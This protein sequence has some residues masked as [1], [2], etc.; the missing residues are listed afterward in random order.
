MSVGLVEERYCLH[1]QYD[2]RIIFASRVIAHAAL[3]DAIYMIHIFVFLS[4]SSSSYLYPILLFY[5]SFYYYDGVRVV[6]CNVY[7]CSMSADRQLWYEDVRRRCYDVYIQE[8][9]RRKHDV[10]H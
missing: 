10:L 9:K 6:V 1:A 2:I 8:C 5:S 3:T 4:F 7:V